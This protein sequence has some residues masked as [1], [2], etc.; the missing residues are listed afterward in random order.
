MSNTN[1][2]GNNEFIECVNTACNYCMY[3]A[4]LVVGVMV[5]LFAAAAR[6]EG[7]SDHF[8]QGLRVR[9]ELGCPYR[10]SVGD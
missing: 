8:L 5:T 1:C 9:L 4:S 3:S 7:P 10:D 6:V 2:V